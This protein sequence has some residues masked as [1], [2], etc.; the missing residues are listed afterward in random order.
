MNFKE[1]W[2]RILDNLPES[3]P[4]PSVETWLRP[5]ELLGITEN[6]ITVQVPNKFYKSWI[7]ENFE[8]ALRESVKK[9]LGIEEP[10]IEY[11]I[12][13]RPKE[14]TE[15]RRTETRP[16]R[17]QLNPKYTFENFVVGPGNQF[18]HASA[19]AV[20]E[21]PGKVYNPLFIYGGVGLGK[22]HLLHAIGHKVI[23]EHDK[24]RVIYTSAEKFMNELIDSI[25]NDRMPEFR[26]RYRRT[27]VLLIDDIQFI[28]G[29]DRTQ[30]E[31]FHTFNELHNEGKQI[32]LTSD[33]P[34]AE[35]DHIE[36]RLKSRFQWGL[37]ADIQPPDLETRIAILKK[38]AEAEG[39]ELPDDVA[40]MIAKRIKSNVRELEGCL[41]K[42]SA[43]AS[44]M[45]KGID[46]E[47]ARKILDSL[48]P[49]QEEDLSPE[50]IVK[51]V[52]EWFG[53]KPSDVKSRRRSRNIVVPRQIAMYLMR[54]LT[55]MSLPDIGEFF[56]GMDH[57][58]VLH[59]VK[60][61]EKLLETDGN[62]RKTVEELERRLEF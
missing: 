51:V 62:I 24:L 48:Y 27:D 1:L 43:M 47:L 59:S 36:E 19:M 13:N 58:S 16:Q 54:K 31:F 7:A 32:V 9:T 28:A 35:M 33:R 6:R 25:K 44:L 26:R 38:K 29:K 49:H 4:K 45:H 42:I 12:E 10:E 15:P 53:L 18:A 52:A 39:I 46:A 60:K 8:S 5:V 22:T 57:S 61:V 37:I 20:A 40:Y 14:K 55:P 2:D 17:P 34:P 30:E 23:K 41:V 56:G 50:T 3:I 11:Q 21:K